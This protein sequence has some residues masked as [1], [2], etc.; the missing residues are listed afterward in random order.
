MD[1]LGVRVGVER[2]VDAKSC[3]PGY[4]HLLRLVFNHAFGMRPVSLL[5]Y[6]HLSS[7]SAASCLVQKLLLCDFIP[8]L[9]RYMT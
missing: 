6:R 1:Q 5:S 7:L 4:R 8:H 2:Q 3:I 9:E